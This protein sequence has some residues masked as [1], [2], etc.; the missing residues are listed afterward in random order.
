MKKLNF[1]Q[2]KDQRKSL[3]PHMRH[4]IPASERLVEQ[5]REKHKNLWKDLPG[6]IQSKLF[7]EAPSQRRTIE[8]LNLN[9]KKIRD[10]V[11]QMI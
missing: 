7:M 3:M 11:G 8:E 2:E 1:S 9:K 5:L 6:L 4:I 10:A